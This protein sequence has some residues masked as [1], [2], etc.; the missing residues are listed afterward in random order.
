MSQTDRSVGS[1]HLR[2]PQHRLLDV[3]DRLVQRRH[4]RRRRHYRR[5]RVA[6]A[7]QAVSRTRVQS[8]IY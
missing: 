5:R 1:P 3:T 2:H 4:D 8:Q 6:D 7:D